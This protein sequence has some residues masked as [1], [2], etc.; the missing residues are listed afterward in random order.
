MWPREG[1][2][3]TVSSR[4]MVAACERLGLDTDALLRAVGIERQ[5]L[6]DPDVRLQGREAAALW[7]KAYELSGDPVLSL[8]AAEAC[9][10]G[11]YKVIDY[12]GSSARTVGEAFRYSARYFKLINT[13]VRVS[14]DE[15]G[16]P[17]TFDVAGEDGPG[18]VTRAYA[19]YCLAAFTLHVRAAT[20]VPFS[21]RLVTFSHRTPPDVS[22]HERVFGC[23]VRFEAE[24]NRLFLDRTVWETP[25]S[26]AHPGVL[27]VLA[28]H[29]EHLLSR[30]PRGPDLIERTRR[31]IGARLRAEPSAD[32][33]AAKRRLPRRCARRPSMSRTL[34][35]R[36]NA[37]A[38]TVYETHAL[39]P[40][41]PGR[42][43]HHQHE[44][45]VLHQV[46]A[47]QATGLQRQA[48]E[49]LQPEPLNNVWCLPKVTC[50]DIEGGTDGD[51]KVHTD[52]LGQFEGKKFLFRR[53]Q[54]N[55]NN[56]RIDGSNRFGELLPLV[57]RQGAKRRGISADTIR[58]AKASPCNELKLFGDALSSPA[59]EVLH[60]HSSSCD[61]NI[62]EEIGPV[63]S[64]HCMGTFESANPDD[65][66]TIL[67]SGY[68]AGESW[69][70]GKAAII[71][72]V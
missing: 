60:R 44:A 49:P 39:G 14:V 10:L 47:V 9:P 2:V 62:A 20:G 65:G 29:A 71:E 8:H 53:A 40:G 6:E 61:H 57:F 18:G 17:I 26:G 27:G 11:A 59:K 50:V 66:N 70:H 31:A 41:E 25:T 54:T 30:L 32:L 42:A 33:A 24:R 46:A 51:D 63:A 35:S 48:E 28:E 56:V 15:S 69:M 43:A 36:V 55:P 23:P 22:E 58:V 67:Q 34:G 4:A 45:W 19:E 5:T 37:D 16:D 21:I 68:I 13:A 3:L 64:F 1:T 12:M 7:A 38:C 52:A 72:V